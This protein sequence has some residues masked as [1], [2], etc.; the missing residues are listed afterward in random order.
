MQMNLRGLLRD[1]ENFTDGSFAALVLDNILC[2]CH[3]CTNTVEVHPSM[4]S[5]CTQSQP[6]PVSSQSQYW[7][8]TFDLF[9][10]IAQY[11]HSA[12]QCT[13]CTRLPSSVHILIEG[14]QLRTKD[15]PRPN[16][17]RVRVHQRQRRCRLNRKAQLKV[18]I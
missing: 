11:L 8:L 7:K 9:C 2:I 14:Q 10:H 6:H 5:F 13:Q 12:T 17:T 3:S 15:A 18:Y 1:C 16:T 4:I